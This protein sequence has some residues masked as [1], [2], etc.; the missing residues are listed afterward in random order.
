MTEPQSRNRRGAPRAGALVFVV[1]DEVVLLL[2]TSAILEAHGYRVQTFRDAESALAAFT[3]ARPRPDLIITDYAMVMMNGL[4]LITEC[5]RVQPAQKV[6]LVS[7]TEDERIFRG[8]ASKPNQF[9]AKPYQAAQLLESVQGVL[10][11]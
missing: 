10:A 4:T 6:I 2:M 3:A 8:A 11:S 7:G 5:R 1:D 9:L